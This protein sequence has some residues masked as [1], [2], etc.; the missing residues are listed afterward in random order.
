MKK[1]EVKSL[2]K[3]YGKIPALK[4]LSFS[5]DGEIFGLVGPNGAGKTTTLNIISGIILPDA[6]EFFV[7]EINGI[8]EKI[9]AKKLIGYLPEEPFFFDYLTGEET[10]NFVS[11]AY[12]IEWEKDDLLKKWMEDLQ[13]MPYLKN[14]VGNYSHGMRQKLAIALSIFHN[15]EVILWDEPFI[16]LDWPSQ[17]KLKEIMK[18]LKNK[19]KTLILSTH[20]LELVEEVCD[21]AAF[22]LDGKIVWEGEDT[23]K[24]KE[25]FY[26]YL[27]E[28]PLGN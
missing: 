9:K 21:R 19:G 12:K 27:K 1:L 25:L 11:S 15:P 24:L 14:M 13:L 7:S 28:E 6:G 5:A 20:H 23:E 10:L 2:I 22:I 8:K 16:G 3:N 18:E 26:D 17:E 4:G